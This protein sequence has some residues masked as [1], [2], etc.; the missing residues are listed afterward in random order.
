[1]ICPWFCHP[2]RIWES[3]RTTLD[4]LQ[5]TLW[6]QPLLAV[7]QIRLRLSMA[8]RILGGMLMEGGNSRKRLY[9]W[10]FGGCQLISLEY[11]PSQFLDVDASQFGKDQVQQGRLENES[12]Q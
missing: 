3:A 11:P 5:Q 4:S 9:P 6:S 1:M 8:F 2:Q 12:L 10:L 7:H